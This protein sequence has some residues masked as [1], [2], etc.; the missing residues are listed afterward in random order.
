MG[1]EI[2]LALS[3]VC[4][5]VKNF[6]H[7]WSGEDHVE[8]ADI[9]ERFPL[10]EA[11]WELLAKACNPFAYSRKY[12]ALQFKRSMATI[13]HTTD[14]TGG[15]SLENVA[16]ELKAALKSDHQIEVLEKI[17]K[18]LETIYESGSYSDKFEATQNIRGN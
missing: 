1:T 11:T 12:K 4:S 9:K 7:L 8:H 13:S 15:R 16:H 3:N 17:L 5:E 14:T 2:E 18:K 10:Q 6:V